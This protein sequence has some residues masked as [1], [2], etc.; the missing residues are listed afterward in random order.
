MALWLPRRMMICLVLHND[1]PWVRRKSIYVKE[2]VI[3]N[4]P[5]FQPLYKTKLWFINW[6][7]HNGKELRGGAEHL[8]A[9]F[10]R[11]KIH[12]YCGECSEVSFNSILTKPQG[13]DKLYNMMQS[14][15][16]RG[17]CLVILLCTH[18]D[19]T[20]RGE[21]NVKLLLSHPNVY[22]SLIVLWSTH[23]GGVS[24]NVA[25]LFFN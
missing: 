13:S 8:T 16:S 18:S 24:G 3:L 4:T 20:Q 15:L 17:E 19:I 1:H 7:Y 12:I 9:P 5:S 6:E 22:L 23:F 11:F 2:G 21:V 10:A 14:T 25:I